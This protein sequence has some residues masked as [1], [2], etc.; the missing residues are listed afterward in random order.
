MNAERAGEIRNLRGLLKNISWLSSCRLNR[1]AAALT[2]NAFWKKR[3]I[4]IDDKH[5]P[6][7][8]YFL[9]SGVAHVTCRNRKGVRTPLI[10]VAPGLI[11]GFSPPVSGI[12]YNFRCEAA[13]DCQIGTIDLKLF[14]EIS[15]GISSIDFKRM[16]VSYLGQWDL[17]QLRCA[18]FLSCTLEERLALLL[19][20]LSENFGVNDERGTRLTVAVRNQDLAALAG[21]S[22]PQ[23]TEFLIQ[24]ERENYISRDERHL[25][26]RRDRLEDFLAETHA[27][28]RNEI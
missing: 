5:S 2:T 19:L 20:E 15:L 8:A 23:V 16:A 12:S 14:I 9:L 24:F 17:V 26:I 10:M 1:L 22:R 13:T 7:S 4:I 6:E 11:P 28:P 3:E 27:H 25:I 21:A 18:N